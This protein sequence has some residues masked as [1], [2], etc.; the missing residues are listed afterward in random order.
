MDK[1]MQILVIEED[2][3]LRESIRSSLERDGFKVYMAE[4]AFSGIGEARKYRPALILLGANKQSGQ[5]VTKLKTN[6]DTRNI[7]VIILTET[8]SIESKKQASDIGADSYITKPLAGRELGEMIKAKL[9][10][11]KKQ[12][13]LI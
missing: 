8:D 5:A 4:N 1:P 6:F 11:L 9:G 12:T 7:P 10:K 3:H 2:E 13:V